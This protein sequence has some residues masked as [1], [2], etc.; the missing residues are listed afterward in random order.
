VVALRKIVT[1]PADRRARWVLLVFWI[2]AAVLLFPLS[3]KLSGVEKNDA[4]S[5]L[6][7][8]AESTKVVD[9]QRKFSSSDS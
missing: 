9:L 5:Y 1:L 4:A 2:V 7:G 3:S 8:N 6:P